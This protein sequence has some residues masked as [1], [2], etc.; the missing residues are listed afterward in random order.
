MVKG[1]NWWNSR[2]AIDSNIFNCI[3][4]TQYNTIEYRTL[5]CLVVCVCASDYLPSLLSELAVARRPPSLP[6]LRLRNE[7]F[8]SVP[9]F[10]YSLVSCRFAFQYVGF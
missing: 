1:K 5:Y 2:N 4:N 10:L 6:I 3:A 8:G 7:L 9:S